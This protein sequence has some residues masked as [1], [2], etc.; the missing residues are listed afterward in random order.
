MGALKHL[1]AQGA[2]GGWTLASVTRF[3]KPV[4][5]C[6]LSA[7]KLH[8]YFISALFCVLWLRAAFKSTLGICAHLHDKIVNVTL[9]SL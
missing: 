1:M 6:M 9:G 3:G 7:L 2:Q 5:I 8:P 4:F